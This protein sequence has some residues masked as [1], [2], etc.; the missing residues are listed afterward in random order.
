MSENKNL[1]AKSNGVTVIKT[2]GNNGSGLT[3]ALIAGGIIASGFVVHGAIKRA[4]ENSVSDN[5]TN[6]EETDDR[7]LWSPSQIASEFNSAMGNNWDGTENQALML[8]AH[9]GRGTRWAK[10]SKAYRKQTGNNLV[11]KISSELETVEFNAFNSIL[12]NNTN[13]LY[14]DKEILSLRNMRTRIFNTKT[15]RAE[16]QSFY[17]NGIN[18]GNVIK[19][20][21]SGAKKYYTLVTFPD[22]LFREEDLIRDYNSLATKIWVK[23]GL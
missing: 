1:P 7:G 22:Y 10:I 8:L 20:V 19:R 11:A 18:L 16:N 21:D 17:W 6:D 12:A 4:K 5:Y 15:N 2:G 3:N 23:T 13:F 14:G 9:K